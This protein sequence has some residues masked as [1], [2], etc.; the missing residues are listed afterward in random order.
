VDRRQADEPWQELKARST[1]E[2]DQ[3]EATL[4]PG[5]TTD[6]A[7][8]ET[9]GEAIA[10]VERLRADL[11]GAPCTDMLSLRAYWALILKLS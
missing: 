8:A 5:I 1:A 4:K 11:V 10:A 7:L 9:D 6:K 3:A 2:R